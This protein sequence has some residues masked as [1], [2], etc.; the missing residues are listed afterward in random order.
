MAKMP[1]K[2]SEDSTGDWLNTYADMVTLLL[3]FFVLLFACSNLDETKLQLIFQAFQSRGQY[4]N[5]QVDELDINAENNGGVTDD[6]P[7]MP[8]G[9]GE[10]PQSFEELYQYFADYIDENNLADSI[11]VQNGKA[12]VTLTF[13][14]DV[15]F[16]GNSYILKAAGRKVLDGF[17]P[18]IKYIQKSIYTLTISGHTADDGTDKTRDMWLS[19][20]RANSVHLHLYDRNT[21]EYSKYRLKACGPNEP[22]MPNDTA[23]GMAKNRRVEIMFIKSE[24]DLTDPDVIMDILQH[25]HGLGSSHFNQTEKP[26]EDIEKLPDGSADKVIGFIEDSLLDIFAPSASEG[27]SII[28]SS[29]FVA[30]SE[31]ESTESE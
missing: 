24:L 15:F 4:L 21:I 20:M 23:D 27:P 29:A 5:T 2:K 9:E 8:G 6:K 22:I 11:S 7:D 1:Q 26:K 31:S 18:A 19:S 25:D 16:D 10:M 17:I 28:D 12:T 30:S 3:T 13:D 14:D